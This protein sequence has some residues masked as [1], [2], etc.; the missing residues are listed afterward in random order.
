M[1]THSR[2]AARPDAGRSA[3]SG[4]VQLLGGHSAVSTR[5]GRPGR[6]WLGLATGVVIGSLLAGGVAVAAIPTAGSG[7]IYAC[8]TVKTGTLRVIDK[9][10]HAKCVKGEAALAWNSAGL[11]GV[12]G[13][14]GTPGAPGVAGPAGAQGIQGTPGVKGDPGAKGD[15]G[16]SGVTPS[17]FRYFSDVAF[18]GVGNDLLIGSVF[19]PAG[20]YQIR[21]HAMAYNAYAATT[22]APEPSVYCALVDASSNRN[23]EY[24]SVPYAPLQS[25]QAG[26][27]GTAQLEIETWLTTLGETFTIRCGEPGHATANSPRGVANVTFTATAVSAN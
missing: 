12:A 23:T 2:E 18:T 15:T 20:S 17:Y 1:T 4:P 7:E 3:V 6:F 13:A 27:T 5:A 19:L 14:A 24:T 22:F 11:R 10:A 8:R 21:V 25:D 9:A 16:A 26:T